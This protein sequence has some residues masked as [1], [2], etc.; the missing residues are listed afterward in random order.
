[1]GPRL[2]LAETIESKH[3]IV[4]VWKQMQNSLNKLSIVEDSIIYFYRKK[5]FHDTNKIV[6]P[7][8]KSNSCDRRS[9]RLSRLLEAL[10]EFC[11]EA[12]RG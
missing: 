7:L 1:M 8:I 9:A 5:S 12:H 11:T 3:K 6:E 4:S 10:A 2:P